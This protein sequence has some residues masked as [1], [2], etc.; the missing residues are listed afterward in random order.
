MTRNVRI[1]VSSTWLDLQPERE[2]VEKVLHRMKDTDFAGMEYFGSRPETTRETSLKQLE[3]SDIYVGIFGQRYGSGITEA[4]YHRAIELGKPC[5]I[6]MKEETLPVPPKHKENDPSQSAKLENLHRELKS[7]HT[8]SSFK[9]PDQLASQVVTDL[10]NFI[11][12]GPQM[13]IA[14][15]AKELSSFL[16][17]I[18]PFLLRIGESAAE[19]SGKSL[20]SD[21]WDKAKALWGKLL[22]KIQASPVATDAL[23]KARVR[24]EDERVKGAFELQIEE[25]LSQDPNWTA[26]LAKLWHQDNVA[27]SLHAN[28]RD[29]KVQ[30]DVRDS[31]IIAGDHNQVR[32]TN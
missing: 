19:E 27:G 18:L 6:Y 29:V 14:T 3:A 13:D 1:F 2:A 12:G 8:I 5:L 21:A 30:G 15:L 20:G 16:F 28:R 31:I 32:G 22:P 9:N 24:V 11:T 7:R 10:Y 23:E 4:E 25:I 17:P 26:E